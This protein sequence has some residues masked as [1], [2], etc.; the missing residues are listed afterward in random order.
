MSFSGNQQ[1]DLMQIGLEGSY[2]W[3]LGIEGGYS[4][5]SSDG[6]INIP[7]LLSISL[8]LGNAATKALG[9]GCNIFTEPEWGWDA[10]EPGKDI[11]P[12]ESMWVGGGSGGF[13]RSW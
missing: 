4:E 6:S 8:A 3:Y 12:N 7:W 2:E 1:A 11:G 10:G 5:P 13:I 9:E